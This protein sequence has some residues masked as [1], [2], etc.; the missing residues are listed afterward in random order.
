MFPLYVLTN[1][2]IPLNQWVKAE[3][4]ERVGN[5]VK[6]KLGL[7]AFRPAWHLCE[8]PLVTH[9]GIKGDDGNIEYM[10]PDYVWC[11]VSYNDDINYQ[12]AA[13]QRGTIN[14]KFVAN[15]AFLDYIPAN[16]F[17]RYRTSPNQLNDWIMA[18]EIYI[19]KVLSD[20]EVR[21]IIKNIGYNPM[22]RKDGDIDLSE[23]G[24]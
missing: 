4:G 21:G 16:G 5:K 20:E 19:H 6:S 17:Y 14:G 1:K 15:R 12:D 7:L 3:C 13:I 11:E 2:Y 8:I 24:F 9:I 18:G 23:Y 22:N 10:H